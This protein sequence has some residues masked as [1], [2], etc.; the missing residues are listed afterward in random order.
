MPALHQTKQP[1]CKRRVIKVTCLLPTKAQLQEAEMSI[2]DTTEAP[3][4]TEPVAPPVAPPAAE[5]APDKNRR[6]RGD[7]EHDVKLTCDKFVTGTLVLPEG[8]TL[9]PHRIAKHIKESDSLDEA[10]STGAVAAVLDRWANDYNFA[11]VN[12]KPKAFVDYTDAGRAEGLTA[13]KQKAHDAK[14]A[15]RA[16]AKAA[17][18]AAAN[19][20]SDN[21]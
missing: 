11:V 12:D 7:L 6:G 18:A 1:T 8:Q 15:A 14:K 4:A 10:P 3:E 20:S 21:G 16:A 5:E 19:P 9:T 13:L 2:T 17:E